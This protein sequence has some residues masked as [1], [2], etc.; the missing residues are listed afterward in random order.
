MLGV[1]LRCGFQGF[2]AHI[3][4]LCEICIL[5]EFLGNLLCI[6]NARNTLLKIYSYPPVGNFYMSF[7]T[8]IEIG[9]L[10]MQVEE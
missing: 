4:S 2:S 10:T 7:G 3:T 6:L 5:K 1:W 8:G 9:L